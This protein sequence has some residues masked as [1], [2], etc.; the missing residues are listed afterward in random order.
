MY[1]YSGRV[2]KVVDGD[3]FDIDLDLGFHVTYRIRVRLKGIDTPEIYHP[4]GKE[5]HDHGKEAK[6]FVKEKIL[7]K[8]VIVHTERYKKGKYGRYIA[9][10]IYNEEFSKRSLSE[11][12]RDNGFEKRKKYR[13]FDL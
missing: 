12:L 4:T 7:D 6:E 3:T 13:L 9:D 10:I 1:E 11:A 8:D 5:E 2:V